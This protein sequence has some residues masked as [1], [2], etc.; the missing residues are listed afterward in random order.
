MLTITESA[1]TVISSTLEANR[2]GG[3]DV[4]R[5]TY[6]GDELALS[7]GGQQDGDLVIS[8]EERPI[9]VLERSVA[10]KLADLIVDTDAEDA[11]RLV[12]RPR[13]AG[14]DA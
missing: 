14:P 12:I 13:N 6:V 3:D 11:S 2:R 4:F 1:G 5:V 8:H 10:D 7:V 9:L